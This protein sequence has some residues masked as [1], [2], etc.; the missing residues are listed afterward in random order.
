MRPYVKSVQRLI[1]GAPQC[2]NPQTDWGL[3]AFNKVTGFLSNP[4]V[5]MWISFAGKFLPAFG[6]TGWPLPDYG[7]AEK[8]HQ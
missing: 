6:G 4:I 2:A 5:E 8:K 1:P 3:W 7:R